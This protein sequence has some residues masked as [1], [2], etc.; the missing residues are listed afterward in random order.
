MLTENRDE[1]EFEYAVGALAAAAKKQRDFRN[2]RVKFWEERKEEVMD[3]IKSTGLTVHESVAEQFSSYSNQ[4]QGA[5]V[6]VDTTLQKNLDE[7][8]GKIRSHRELAKEYEG[9]VQV[10]EASPLDNRLKLKH[11]DWMFFFGK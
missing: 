3:K 5:R 11:G 8:V 7:C 6:M 2:S 4:G 9:W 10:L 1:W